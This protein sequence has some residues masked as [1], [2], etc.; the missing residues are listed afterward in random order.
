MYCGL[1]FNL[2]IYLLNISDILLVNIIFNSGKKKKKLNLLYVYLLED[3][4]IV[5]EISK[6]T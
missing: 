5:F 2:F 3:I 6:C 1:L 4:Y